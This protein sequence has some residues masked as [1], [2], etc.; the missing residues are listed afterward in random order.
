MSTCFHLRC[1]TEIQTD[2]SNNNFCPQCTYSTINHHQQLH[3]SK[4]TTPLVRPELRRL[5]SAHSDQNDKQIA[6]NNIQ[7]TSYYSYT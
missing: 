3:T 1:L 6:L 4:T 7:T 5:T 2:Q